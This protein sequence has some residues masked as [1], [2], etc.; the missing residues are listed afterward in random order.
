VA[1]IKLFGDDDDRVKG[2]DEPQ[3]KGAVVAGERIAKAPTTDR[4]SEGS[5]PLE[6]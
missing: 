6:R 1:D 4:R 5:R 2:Q 3:A